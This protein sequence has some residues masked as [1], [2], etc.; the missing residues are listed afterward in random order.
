MKRGSAALLDI[1]LK[2]E[3]ARVE[4]AKSKV[5]EL[6]HD[7]YKRLL[8]KLE[9]RNPG[10]IAYVYVDKDDMDLHTKANRGALGAFGSKLG[11]ASMRLSPTSET[12]ALGLAEQEDIRR[13]AAAKAEKEKDKKPDTTASTKTTAPAPTLSGNDYE[14]AYFY[15][16]DL[17]DAALEMLEENGMDTE[18]NKF[19]VMTGPIIFGTENAKININIA[20]IPVSVSEFQHWFT[21]NVIKKGKNS[22]SI[23]QFLKDITTKIVFP[24]L[25]GR[26]YER[27]IPISA[28]GGNKFGMSVLT[29]P[30]SPFKD[31]KRRLVVDQLTENL[32]KV[33]K[34]LAAQ[35]SSERIFEVLLLHADFIPSVSRR[36]DMKDDLKNGIYHLV[37]GRDKGLV[38]EISLSKESLPFYKEDRMHMEGK[39]ERIAHPY[40]ADIKMV[41]NTYFIPGSRVFVNPALTNGGSASSKNSIVSKLGLGG[42]YVILG[43]VL[44]I[45]GHTFETQLRTK[46]DSNGFKT[47]P[48]TP[49]P[50]S[51]KMTRTSPSS[52]PENT[53][54]LGET[55]VRRS[56]PLTIEEAALSEAI[57][58]EAEHSLEET[59]AFIKGKTYDYWSAALSYVDE[60]ALG[61]PE[62]RADAAGR[63]TGFAEIKDI[64]RK[65]NGNIYVVF[66]PGGASSL[67]NQDVPRQ[68]IS[69]S[70][71]RSP[72]PGDYVFRGG[73]E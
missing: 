28:R 26:C 65:A 27:E 60:S 7:A 39:I 59:R 3:T 30:S 35:T 21:E 63:T 64:R 14:F 67:L 22:W 34:N 16:G 13:T 11:T 18:K 32:Q 43:V 2:S 41:G 48:K 66:H 29:Y 55:D 4:K 24:A 6:K 19:N 31:K 52:T 40:V 23:A 70:R 61:R 38:K 47:E 53:K 15:L 45:T 33:Q 69:A 68:S 10:G 1:A 71:L 8:T 51:G 58:G 25:G 12:G 46:W 57:K 36:G 17:I 44:N 72:K 49:R 20:D 54:V 73:D 9:G 42:Y 37:L 62:L 50:E 5:L 56:T